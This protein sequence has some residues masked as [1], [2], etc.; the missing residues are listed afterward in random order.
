MRK[1][2]DFRL[3]TQY[4]SI[5]CFAL[6]SANALAGP[7]KFD[8]GIGY[9]SVNAKTATAS[10]STSGPGL[11][12]FNFRRAITTKFEFT[13]GYTVYFSSLISGDSGSG[14]D[15]GVN[16]FPL[17]FSGPVEAAGPGAS[18]SIDEIWRPYL[19]VT[20]N[21]RN[22]QSVQ[23]TYTGYGIHIGIERSLTDTLNLNGMARTIKLSGPRQ[24]TGTETDFLVGAGFK[25]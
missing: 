11:Y 25:F 3:I 7:N 10:G 20:F 13:I 23:T 22:F 24:S 2:P 16:Y 4:L 15:I 9:Y 1:Q 14:L 8:L 5:A 12:Q 6:F 19:G 17:T 18:I 21:Q